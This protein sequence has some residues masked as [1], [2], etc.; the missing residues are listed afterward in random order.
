V[1]PHE[2]LYSRNDNY[3]TLVFPYQGY[4]MFFDGN[5]RLDGEVYFEPQ[6]YE[7]Q[8]SISI[9]RG[10]F[11]FSFTKREELPLFLR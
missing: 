2:T 7:Y 8:Q 3:Y 6:R 4:A 11:N 10:S 9:S 1:Y 5:G